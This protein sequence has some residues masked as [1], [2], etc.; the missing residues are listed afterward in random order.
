MF[1][2]RFAVSLATLAL[3]VS[4]SVPALSATV[5]GASCIVVNDG[6][7]AASART[8]G[9]IICEELRQN[10]VIV[11]PEGSSTADAYR[12]RFERLGE[13]VIVSVSYEAPP[14]RVT[15]SR[16]LVMN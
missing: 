16:R 12:V 5:P 10:G 7:D 14:G 1:D 4:L 13:H 2:T 9:R 3:G 8:G 11:A 6:L 15:R